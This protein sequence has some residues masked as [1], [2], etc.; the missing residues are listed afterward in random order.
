MFSSILNSIYNSLFS[1]V[2]EILPNLWLGDSTISADYKFMLDNR[3]DIIVNC[4]PNLPFVLD[5]KKFD[6]EQIKSLQHL[7]YIRLPVYDSLLQRDLIL[8]EQ[9]LKIIIP[10]LYIEFNR[11]KKI[12]IHCHA[13]KQRSAIVAVALLYL[14]FKN[15]QPTCN[16]TTK[17]LV[18][19]TFRFIQLK[20]PQVFTYGLRT[21]F[22]DSFNRFYH[23][24][25]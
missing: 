5:T 17:D 24:D 15:Q 9:Y 22:I 23:I 1:H 4:T 19:Y 16:L 13:G 14:V 12:L 20:R 3:I 2:N 8:M 18:D 11:G 21:N 25:N 6:S 7:V 10:F